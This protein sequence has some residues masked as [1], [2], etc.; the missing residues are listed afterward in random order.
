MSPDR[1]LVPITS[2]RPFGRDEGATASSRFASL[3]PPHRPPRARSSIDLSCNAFSPCRIALPRGRTESRNL[4][5][6]AT[7]RCLR[8]DSSLRARFANRTTSRSPIS[9]ST[10]STWLTR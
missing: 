1:S 2:H 3:Q 7:E 9:S 8:L 6:A 10:A 5:F 4:S